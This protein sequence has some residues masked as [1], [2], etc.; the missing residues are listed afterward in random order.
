MTL[1]TLLLRLIYS[2]YWVPLF[3]LELYTLL[4]IILLLPLVFIT[5]CYSIGAI[6]TLLGVLMETIYL[7]LTYYS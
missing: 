7:S 1:A 2:S 5:A 4:L 3:Q 6:V